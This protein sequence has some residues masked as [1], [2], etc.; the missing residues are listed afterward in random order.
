MLKRNQ[1]SISS[2][3][4]WQTIAEFSL[5]DEVGSENQAAEMVAKILVGVPVPDQILREA[6][7]AVTEAIEN[8]LSRELAHQAQRILTILVWIQSAQLL[9]APADEADYGDSRSLPKGWG[10]FLTEKILKET[11]LSSEMDR[12]VISLYLYH[13]GKPHQSSA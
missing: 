13:E 9:E 7:Q 4:Q 12:V 10:F 5:H 8:E 2:E 11:K 3:G 6:K 1:W